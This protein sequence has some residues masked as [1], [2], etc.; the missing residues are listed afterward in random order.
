[1]ILALSSKTALRVLKCPWGVQV[2]NLINPLLPGSLLLLLLQGHFRQGN[3]KYS[4][5]G[6][7]RIEEKKD[8]I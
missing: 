7:R 6:R 3:L 4:S 5:R 8:L 2:V 1:M